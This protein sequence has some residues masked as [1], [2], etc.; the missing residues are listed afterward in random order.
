VRVF[1]TPEYSN[2]PRLQNLR[3]NLIGRCDGGTLR[4]C[5]LNPAAKSIIFEL[6]RAPCA[7]QRDA[8]QPILVIPAVG[9]RAGARDFRQRIAVVMNVQNR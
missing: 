6:E 1:N 4:K 3:I 9:C 8:R 5:L 2:S 7:G